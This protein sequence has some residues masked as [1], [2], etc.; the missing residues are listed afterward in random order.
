MAIGL[1]AVIGLAWLLSGPIYI[2]FLHNPALNSGIFVVLLIGMTYI[3]WQVVRLY[4]EI[5]WIERLKRNEL[6]NSGDPE[7]RLLAPMAAMVRERTSRLTLST[8]A[9]RSLL[10]SISSR[11]DESRDISRYF[12]GL[13][14]FL[15]LLGTFWGLLGTI[16]GVAEAIGAISVTSGGDV[17]SLFGQLKAGLERPLAGM[18]TAFSASL[19]GLSGSLMLG[20]LELLASQAQNRFFNELEDWLAERTRLT[21]AGS[22]S[23]GD[24][25]V[26]VYIQALLEQTADN[27]E[28]LQRIVSRGE[29]SRTQANQQMN[30]LVERLGGLTDQMRTEA[31]LMMKLAESQ[32][33]MRPVIARLAEAMQA[34]RFGIDEQSRTHLRNMDSQLSR[35]ADESIRGRQSALQEL[36]NDIKKLADSQ[37]DM[38]PLLSRLQDLFKGGGFGL[39]DQSRQHLRN[40]DGQLGRLM[41]DVSRGRQESVQELRSEIKV[42]ARTIAALADEGERR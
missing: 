36:R 11:L 14:V 7:P 13:M 15:G 6:G 19:F 3:F 42:L 24:Q 34:G 31:Q 17:A 35:L 9:L 25:S 8:A 22:V 41:E 5:E 33:E 1:A 26:P 38:R 23:D 29:D 30:A 10:D 39:D 40:L 20:Y 18:G 21:S 32:T 37:I 28:N 4:P 2:A 12:I 16:S 27:L